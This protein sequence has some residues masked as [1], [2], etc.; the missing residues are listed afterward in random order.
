MQ[1]PA[2]KEQLKLHLLIMQLFYQGQSGKMRP[3]SLTLSSIHA[4]TMKQQQI[5]TKMNWHTNLLKCNGHTY[6][7]MEEG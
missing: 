7:I 3:G 5:H 4:K 1:N 2:E 6:A